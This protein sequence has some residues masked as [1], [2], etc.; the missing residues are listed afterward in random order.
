MVQT[1][2]SRQELRAM[3]ELLLLGIIWGGSFLLMR[4]AA[5][6]FG[7]WALVE[8]RLLAGSLVLLPL[9]LRARRQL[10][11][12]WPVLFLIGAIN[13]ATPFALFAWA[14][15]VAPAGI[16]A[17]ANSMTALFTVI[18]AALM[19]GERVGL[20]RTLG[21]LLGIAGV[22]VMLGAPATDGAVGPA[23]LAATLAAACYGLS[24]NL[25]RRHL[26]GLPAGALGGATL[27]C[28]TLLALPLALW[29]WPQV[30]P[31]AAAWGSALTLGILCTGIAY[32]YLFRLI[33]A[34]GPSRTATVTYLIP[35][36]GVAWAWLVLDEPV[37]SAM[38]LAGALILGGVA[39]SQRR[40]STAVL[41]QQI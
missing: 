23:A 28:A 34:I 20:I 31:S 32:V 25:T 22:L 1:V 14:T 10:A 21:L 6:E 39:L 35:L 33:E 37:T 5:P 17:I 41:S 26:S 18:F 11:G 29:Q 13:S 24:N 4:I 7:P 19:F 3:I 2:S 15:M 30:N 40:Q 16:S 12:R 9:V 27:L 8:L 38:I 36:F